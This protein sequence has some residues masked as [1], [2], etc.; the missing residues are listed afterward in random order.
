MEQIEVLNNTTIFNKKGKPPI[1]FIESTNNAR[2]RFSV[3]AV[4]L[5]QLKEG[6]RISFA[7]LEQE[8]EMIYFYEDAANGMQLTKLSDGKSGFALA[9]YSRPLARKLLAQ[10]HYKDTHKTFT[11]TKD[12]TEVAGIK[13]WFINK[14][15]QHTPIQW[16]R[17][18]TMV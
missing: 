5:L 4:K 2:I 8:R 1:L 6:M 3:E 16:R 14:F 18:E 7:L 9:M 12:T 13:M 17:K 15:K 11:V 10:F